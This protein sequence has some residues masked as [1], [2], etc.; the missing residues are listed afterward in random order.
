MANVLKLLRNNELFATREAALANVTS[1]AQGLGDG[2]VWVATYGVSPNAKSILAVKRTWGVTIFDMEA[3]SGDIDSRIAAAIQA[4]G[5]ATIATSGLASD[6]TTSPIAGSSSTVAVTGSNAADQIAS[7]ATTLKSVQDNASKYKIVKLTAAEVTALSD[8]NVKE[9]YKLVS[10]QGEETAQT[11]YTQVG[12]V[13]KIYKDSSLAET[14]LGSGDDTVN[15][16]TG[17]V[18]KYAYELISDPTTKITAEAYNELTAEQKALYEPIDTQSLNFVYQLADGTYQLVKVDVSKF[19]SESEF[20]SGLDVSPSGVVSVKVDSTSADAEEFISVGPDG[21]KISGVQNAINSALGNVVG[22][23][24]AEVKG[25]LDA[26]DDTKVATGKHVGVKIVEQDGILTS[27]TV[28]EDDIASASSLDDLD[29]TVSAALNDLESRKADKTDLDDL[30][31]DMLE[32]VVAGNGINVSTKANNSQTVSVKLD[33]VQTDNALSVGSD[34][35]YFSK[36]I[37]CGDY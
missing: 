28:V 3:I 24:D 6:A 7:L 31:G 1:R 18:T 13:I 9:A 25:S 34:G 12:D 22:G 30:E 17:V 4:L 33:T 36:T 37:D 2:E 15:S 19:L 20:G 5:L 26:N 21:V 32:A 23:L 14:Y 27:V 8:E 10:F 11:V 16:S 35:L 29:L